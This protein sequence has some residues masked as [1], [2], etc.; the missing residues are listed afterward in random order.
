MHW[1]PH[2]YAR[3]IVFGRGQWLE[4]WPNDPDGENIPFGDLSSIPGGQPIIS[5]LLDLWKMGKLY[6]RPATDEEKRLAWR[7]P[8]AVL[9][10]RPVER[11]E[12]RSLGPYGR[13]DIG[14]PRSQPKIFD[15]NGKPV[16]R[17]WKRLGAITPKLCL[18][19]EIVDPEEELLSDD[20]TDLAS[21]VGSDPIENWS[22]A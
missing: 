22:D 19:D 6:F 14:R 20:E 17:R 9:P 7:N 1:T 15:A 12:P 18:Q 8:E 3:S 13:N 10:G 5:R 4:G 11:P 16:G 2:G 21:A